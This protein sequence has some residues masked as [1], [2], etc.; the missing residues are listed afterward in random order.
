MTDSLNR[1][2]D[3]I[4][5]VVDLLEFHSRRQARLELRQH[6]LHPLGYL[7]G[8][9]ATELI[10]RQAHRGHAPDIGGVDVVGLTAEADAAHIPQP[11]QRP[12]AGVAQ[13]QILEIFVLQQPALELHR[14]GVGLALGRRCSPDSPGRNQAI[15]ALQGG[16]H[17]GGTEVLLG[18]AVGIEPQPHRQTAVAEIGELPYAPHPPHLVGQPLVQ[19]AAEGLDAVGPIRIAAHQVVNQ[20]HRVG[21]LVH[22]HP[23]LAHLSG[24]LRFG[25]GHPV[26]HIHLVDGAIGAANEG[27]ADGTAA[28]GGT[29][30]GDELHV[31]HPI[32]LLLQHRGDP[33]F[34][35]HRIGAGVSGTHLHCWW[36]D[37]GQVLDRQ[38][39]QGDQP[40]DHDQQAADRGEHRPEDEA[41]RGRHLMSF[42]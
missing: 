33:L 22:R 6:L 12:F 38:D 1:G 30:G 23:R 42:P 41:V 5:D 14:K 8:I 40:G 2:A 13:D 9:A 25:Q 24:Q 15:L 20:Q 19:L 7:Q 32:D 36:C 4:G 37:V 21:G 35:A 11:H 26:L 17:I 3:E 10:D 31:L 18:E 29:G 27:D 39:W 28:I 16:H 34:D